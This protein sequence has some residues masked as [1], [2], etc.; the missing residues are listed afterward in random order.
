MKRLIAEANPREDRDTEELQVGSARRSCGNVELH[1]CHHGSKD[2][3]LFTQEQTRN[4]PE[5]EEVR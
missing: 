2:T 4:N 5:K 1:R 3:K